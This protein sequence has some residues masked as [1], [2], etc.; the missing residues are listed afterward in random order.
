MYLQAC[1]PHVLQ[2]KVQTAIGALSVQN[3]C[4]C[5]CFVQASAWGY[6]AKELPGKTITRL[7]KLLARNDGKEKNSIV[8]PKN[9]AFAGSSLEGPSLWL[10]LFLLVPASVFTAFY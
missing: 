2:G 7:S 8:F 1:V 3:H 10:L 4:L 9:T 6:V 5:Y